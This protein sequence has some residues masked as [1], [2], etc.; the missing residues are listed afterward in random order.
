MDDWLIFGE[1]VFE[2]ER[3]LQRQ[4]YAANYDWLATWSLVVTGISLGRSL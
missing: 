4:G 1:L 3:C 2:V